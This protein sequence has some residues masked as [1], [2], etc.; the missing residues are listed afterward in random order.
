MKTYKARGVVLNTVKYG[1]SGLIVY[2]YTNVFGRQT[3]MVKGVRSSRGKGNKAALFQPM[4]LL[5]FEGSEP[6][7]GQMHHMKDVVPF[8]TLSS[9]PFDVRKSTMALFMAEVVYRLIRESEPD[10]N[11]FNF[12]SKSVISLDK[13][14]EGIANFH[15]WFLV[16]LTQFLGFY[17]GNE[18][19]AGYI[20]DIIK[21]LFVT[22]VPEHGMFMPE[23]D[24]RLLGV[25]MDAEM[26][27]LS[28]IRLSR[29]ERVSFLNSLLLFIGYHADSVNSVKSVDILREVF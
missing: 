28:E 24:S 16:G 29:T 2:L 15:L 18:Y 25:L 23:N 14:T 17:P 5:E 3:Y 11:L 1:D 21:G 12:I 9:L 20:F 10:E 22:R 8:V 19:T 6:R 4:F 13:Q 27:R 26:S 7:Y